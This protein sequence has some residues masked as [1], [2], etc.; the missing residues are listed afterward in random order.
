VRGY[1]GAGFAHDAE[2]GYNETMKGTNMFQELKETEPG[3]VA[4]EFEGK[5]FTFN[6]NP[7]N[8]WQFAM[9]V[10]RAVEECEGLAQAKFDTIDNQEDFVA[11]EG[12][13]SKLSRVAADGFWYATREY[14]SRTHAALVH[15][16]TIRKMVRDVYMKEN[17]HAPADATN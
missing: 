6:V 2:F 16:F 8:G 13:E 11:W 4:F 9:D 15:R 5:S 12:M 7:D 17:A 3:K 14:N 10:V 1:P